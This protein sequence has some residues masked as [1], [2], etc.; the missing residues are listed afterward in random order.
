MEPILEHPWE[1]SPEEAILIQQRLREFVIIE[2]QLGEIL[3]I[4]G[5]D[6]SYDPSRQEARG[7]VTILSYPN[8]ELVVYVTAITPSSFPYIPGLLS[9]REIPPLLTCFKKLKYHPD[10][11]L[12]DGH[13]LAHPRRFGL[14]CH[15]GVL[16]D[17]PSMG[18]AK[19]PLL[20][21]HKTLPEV[22]GAWEPVIDEGEIIGVAM[23]SR[24]NNRPIYISIGHRISLATS[25]EWVMNCLT[26]YRLPEPIRWADRLSKT[27]TIPNA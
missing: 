17:I 7:V 27:N 24:T 4:A 15:L 26:Q 9:F 13:G 1:I 16:F 6:V 5:A 22:R 19:R 8:L 18:V 20:G 23:R 21:E 3:S 25:I 11:I 12:C 14:A 10:L 2:D